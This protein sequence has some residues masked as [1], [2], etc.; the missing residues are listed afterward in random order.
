MVYWDKRSD[1]F[2]QSFEVKVY[3]WATDDAGAPFEVDKMKV[4][5]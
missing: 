4:S 1:A 5:W 2:Y 3:G